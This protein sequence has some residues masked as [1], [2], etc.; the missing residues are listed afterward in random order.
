MNIGVRLSRVVRNGNVQSMYKES[1]PFSAF[2]PYD[3]R[4]TVSRGS[5]FLSQKTEFIVSN[6]ACP[7]L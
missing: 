1:T 3:C 4:P 6:T 5:N 2:P 7:K